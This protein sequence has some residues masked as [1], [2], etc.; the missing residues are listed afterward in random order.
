[1]GRHGVVGGAAVR[2]AGGNAG[3][4]V[5]SFRQQG[6]GHAID[7]VDGDDDGFGVGA[8]LVGRVERDGK[9]VGFHGRRAAEQATGGTRVGG[10]GKR[11]PSRNAFGPETHGIAVDRIAG[12]NRE[13]QQLV[14]GDG[15][16]ADGRK[17][18]RIVARGEGR[19]IGHDQREILIQRAAVVGHAVGVDVEGADRHLH[20][21]RRPR[22]QEDAFHVVADVGGAAGHRIGAAEDV[23]LVDR[24]VHADHEIEVVL[25]GVAGRGPGGIRP[26]QGD[27]HR[28]GRIRNQAVERP[29]LP[30]RGEKIVGQLIAQDAGRSV[31]GHAEVHA[32]DA[33]VVGRQVVVGVHAGHVAG[34]V[35]QEDLEH[36]RAGHAPALVDEILV[37]QRRAARDR[38][39]GMAGAAGGGVIGLACRLV[40]VAHPVARVAGI[41]AGR[42]LDVRARRH[43]VR[44]DALVRT[45]PAAR[46]IDDVVG[47]VGARVV[48][49]APVRPELVVVFRRADGE[50]VLGGSGRADGRGAGPVVAGR[51]D[52]QAFLV[53]GD[54]GLRVAGDGVGA[55]RV[56][57]V[58]A[59]ARHAPAVRTD[60]HAFGVVGA[61]VGQLLLVRGIPFALVVEHLG[62]AQIGERADA[63]SEIVARGVFIR[64]AGQVIVA[65]DDADV[66][67]AV[68]IRA[69][70]SG[71]RQRAAPLRILDA[72][73]AGGA[74]VL[75]EFRIGGA[76]RDAVVPPV[77]GD[78][79]D[80]SR[81]VELVLR[82][83]LGRQPGQIAGAGGLAAVAVEVAGDDLALPLAAPLRR[84]VGVDGD[85]VRPGRDFVQAIAGQGHDD[86]QELQPA[87]D[88]AAAQ[89]RQLQAV[90]QGERCG[91]GR[92]VQD[93]LH[94]EQAVRTGGR[95]ARRQRFGTRARLDLVAGQ[96]RPF[97]LHLPG[98][99]AHGAQRRGTA[100]DQIGVLRNVIH[101]AVA[102]LRQLLHPFRLDR[103][104]E[105]HQMQPLARKL[106]RDRARRRLLGGAAGIDVAGV[107]VDGLRRTG[108]KDGEKR[109]KSCKGKT[110]GRLH[111][112]APVLW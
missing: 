40:L 55:L 91:V 46:E 96:I 107:E 22:R 7:V 112:D 109:Q 37:N 98:M 106:V 85:H 34:G 108:R 76:A 42:A 52:E 13:L 86:V 2:P 95:P 18:R 110:E 90:H 69:P 82:E 84:H 15:F 80:E 94:R 14:G 105:L 10:S 87:V 66:D 56:D 73:G 16:V 71:G 21:A 77:V 26:A 93:H 32:A 65:A 48:H 19:G 59:V 4:F 25:V 70:G 74:A 60:P 29:G 45:R 28:L 24:A 57:V 88:A 111:G 41:E 35:H 20:E 43:D 12:G 63:E 3:R 23:A 62:V 53:A 8:V 103:T 54:A 17:G 30:G 33:L 47:V 79:H 1:M 102:G 97:P 49:G 100:I 78:V 51:V 99:G 11:G 101:D 89:G 68:A 61:D 64:A 36:G 27:P 6:G 72:A 67:V 81:C 39:G 50:D 58:H 104:G 44:L 92:V 9:D 38:R 31:E 75:A 83:P 5:E